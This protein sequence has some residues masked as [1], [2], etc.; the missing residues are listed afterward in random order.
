M[1][2]PLAPQGLTPKP[3]IQL[4]LQWYQRR[5]IWGVLVVEFKMPSGPDI[6]V[7]GAADC[8]GHGIILVIYPGSKVED[9]LPIRLHTEAF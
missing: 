4:L 7:I 9:G 8:V 6:E 2:R 5:E 3:L 1:Q